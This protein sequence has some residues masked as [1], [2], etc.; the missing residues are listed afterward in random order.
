MNNKKKTP[1]TVSVSVLSQ[2][3]RY[4]AHLEVDMDEVFRGAG[5]D[6]G[7]L[8]NPDARIPIETYIAIED[9]SVRIS[10]DPY[11]GLHMGEFAEPGSWSILGYMMMNCRTLSEAAEKSARYSNIIGN[12]IQTKAVLGWGTV[13][14]VLSTPKHAPVLSRHCFESTLSSTARI[15]RSLTGK[16][17]D[18]LEVN[19]SYP[20]PAST[21]EYE[22]IFRSPVL[23]DQKQTSITYDIR[24]GNTPV[25]QPSQKLLEQFENYA[26]EYLAEIEGIDKTTRAVTKHI[27]A[28]MDSKNLTLSNIAGE[29]SMSVRTLQNHLKSEGVVFRELLKDTRERLA[30]K[31]LC[32]NYTVEDITYLLGF[33]EPSVFRKAF[34][35]WSG[36]TPREYRET[37]SMRNVRGMN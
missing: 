27:L 11:F 10:K 7:F 28:R 34:K 37:T 19:F 17:I 5:V 23:F 22:R 2:L 14:I 24:V 21:S 18:P 20:Q 6:P 31:Y 26:Q 33:S 13:K 35:K 1:I 15:G 16:Q 25:L 4:L 30:K 36:S 8:K 32:E 12:L 29:M 9:E 3:L